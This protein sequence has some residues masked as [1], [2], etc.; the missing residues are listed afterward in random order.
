[1]D[2]QNVKAVRLLSSNPGILRSVR[3]EAVL[4]RAL[5]RNLLMA[6]FFLCIL[7][8]ALA[9]IISFMGSTVLSQAAVSSASRFLWG[10]TLLLVSP[11]L[12]FLIAEFYFLTTSRTEPL[13][14]VSFS[15]G[16]NMFL[17]NFGAIRRL[18]QLDAFRTSTV[19]AARLYETFQDDTFSKNFFMRL[20]IPWKAVG[21][22]VKSRKNSLELSQDTLFETLVQEAH[23]S[24][25]N[26][27]TAREFMLL[28]FDLDKE[29]EE[30]LFQYEIR[31]EDARGAADWVSDLLQA[32]QAR[33][34]WWERAVLGRMPTFGANLLFGYTYILDQFARDVS[35]GSQGA[36]IPRGFIHGKELEEMV[37][38][39]ARSAQANAILVGEPGIGKMALLEQLAHLILEGQAPSA[40]WEKRLVALDTMALTAT[41]KNKGDLEALLI[42]VMNEASRA[43]NIVLILEK[44]SEFIESASYLGVNAVSIL[45]PYLEGTELQVV[46]L[47]DSEQYHRVLERNATVTKL[48][49][50][51]ELAEPE[52]LPAVYVLEEIAYELEKKYP[53]VVTYP[54]L[55][56]AVDLAERYITEGA[57]PE[58][59]V[60]LL[61][62]GIT[63]AISVKEYIVGKHH[64]ERAVEK[65]TH[66]PVHKAE[67]EEAK[68]LL[69][70]E[71]FLHKRVIGQ[72]AA[73]TAIAN[74][75][76]RARAGL[77]AGKRPI[78]SFLF[79]GP[80]GVGKTETAKALAEVY[81]KSEEA[82]A[83]FDMSEFQGPEGVNKLIGS[84]D[85]GETG[86]LANALRE[87]P[88]SLLLFD[89]FEKSSRDVINL[90]LQILEEGFFADAKGKRVSARDSIIIT[91]SNAGS[92]I[93]WELVQQGKDPAVLQKEVVDM[94]RR[95]G[96]FMPE[97]LNRFDAIIVFEPLDKT[98]LVSVARLL[99]EELAQRLKKQDVELVITDELVAKVVEIGYDPV[100]GARPMRRAIADRIEQIIAR[101]LLDGSLQRGQT[102]Q[103]TNEEISRL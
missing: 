86:A 90:F 41:T 80:T 3:L 16:E 78:G 61:E 19:Q 32:E 8:G 4:P 20:G 87:K 6:F 5:R 54:A 89:E 26:M 56:A 33:L 29:F 98:K 79:L 76:R 28:L 46:A 94:I 101:K 43:G 24:H 99:L 58:K 25:T 70:M 39:L 31:K 1:M 44:F 36:I 88:F 30:F 73:I 15:D 102:F 2:D 9:L 45:E 52:R 72:D 95:E 51:V 53:T 57:M 23:E 37:Q 103:F 48:F 13:W 11:F 59:A 50:K 65:R 35:A 17:C 84:F 77:H 49:E 92:N 34:R 71:E 62:R 66:I 96:I 10:L 64:I 69:R 12:F 21:E 42:K 22:F 81:F 68:E 7:L 27:V 82:M 83:R 100:M 93:I 18:W 38:I 60:D 40:L 55:L 85:A 14:S 67:G 63:E 47:A 91:T 75:M 97:I 74:T